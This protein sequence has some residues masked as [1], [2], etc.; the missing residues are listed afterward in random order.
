MK[1]GDPK[2]LIFKW[3][4]EIQLLGETRICS[5]LFYADDYDVS[6]WDDLQ[7]PSHWQL[8]GYGKPHI[9]MFNI[10]SR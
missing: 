3:N 2:A 5:T 4:V 9:Q 10:L 8:N 6:D 1:E 7:V